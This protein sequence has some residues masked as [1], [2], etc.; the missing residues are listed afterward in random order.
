MKRIG[1]WIGVLC[2][3]DSRGMGLVKGIGAG[4]IGAAVVVGVAAL[5]VGVGAPLRFSA[6]AAFLSGA[7]CGALVGSKNFNW[8]DATVGSV[9]R[10]VSAGVGS[11]TANW[12]SLLTRAAVAV[13]DI[14]GGGF[15]ERHQPPNQ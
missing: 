4:L 3:L 7:I 8:T 11:L 2:C 9:I 1:Q 5:V 13:A 12:R 6:G 10:G 14:V 15:D